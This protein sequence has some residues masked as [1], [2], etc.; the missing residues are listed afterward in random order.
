MPPPKPKF[1]ATTDSWWKDAYIGMDHIV[2]QYELQFEG[3]LIKP[4]DRIKIKNKRSSFVFRCL[5]H[6]VR[7]DTTWIDCIDEESGEWRSFRVHE[8]KC[9]IKPKKSR[10]KKKNL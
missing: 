2:A 5:A 10:R 8:I 6:N 7:L 1:N 4:G 9:L 3:D